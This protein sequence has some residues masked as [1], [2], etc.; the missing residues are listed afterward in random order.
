VGA[1]DAIVVHLGP[2][3]REKQLGRL[4]ENPRSHITVPAVPVLMIFVW[5]PLDMFSTGVF[6]PGSRYSSA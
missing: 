3:Q 6:C 4:K 1:V 5:T 2:L